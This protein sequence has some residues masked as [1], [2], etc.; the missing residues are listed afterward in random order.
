M[1]TTS[2]FKNLIYDDQGP[3]VSVLLKSEFTKEIRIVFKANQSMKEHQTPHPIVVQIVDGE[4]DFG[5]KG[6]VHHLT[7]GDMLCLEGGVPHDLKANTDS[8]VR[9]TLST[10]DKVERVK[11]VPTN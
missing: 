6:E 9:L 7:K 3:S 8:V 11:K 10:L 4:I 5:V 2:I 1:I